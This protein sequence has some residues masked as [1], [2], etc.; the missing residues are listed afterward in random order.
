VRCPLPCCCK[1]VERGREHICQNHDGPFTVAHGWAAEFMDGGRVL[2]RAIKRL[3][4]ILETARK[5]EHTVVP[6]LPMNSADEIMEYTQ[7]GWRLTRMQC[8]A[9][10]CTG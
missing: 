6:N 10:G 4:T 5:H 7:V 8:I 9:Q 2:K 1:W 3:N